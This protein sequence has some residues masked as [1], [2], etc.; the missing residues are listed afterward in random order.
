LKEEAAKDFCKDKNLK[1]KLIDP[2]KTISK[3]KL[4]EILKKGELVFLKRYQIKFENYV[5]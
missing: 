2:I 1:Y 3:E 5:S 4:G